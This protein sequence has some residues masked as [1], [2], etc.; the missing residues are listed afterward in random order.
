MADL[1]HWFDGDYRI[2]GPNVDSDA[3]EGFDGSKP[4]P[5]TTGAGPTF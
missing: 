3:A 5:D 2:A 1:T 4:D